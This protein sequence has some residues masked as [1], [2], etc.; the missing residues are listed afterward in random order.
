MAGTNQWTLLFFFASDNALSPLTVSDLRALKDAGFQL[1]TTVLAHFDPNELGAP[2]QI[3][4]VNQ[5]L[6]QAAQRSRIGDGRDSQARSLK[7]DCVEPDAMKTTAGG[8]SRHTKTKQKKADQID[9]ET[10]LRDFLGFAQKNHP[11]QHYM[12]FLVGHGMIVGS[13]TFLPDDRPMGAISLKK[14]DDILREFADQVRNDGSQFEL[15]GLHSCSMSAIEVAYQL[16]G[17]AN[18]MMGTEG[19]SYVGS[20]SYRQLLKKIFNTIEAAQKKQAK[21][22]QD[23]EGKVNVPNLVSELYYLCLLNATDYTFAGYS[24]DLSLCRLQVTEVEKLKEPIQQLV[25]VLKGA[26]DDKRGIELI[27]L[28]HWRAQSYWHETYTDL[29]D[30]CKCLR[31]ACDAK[32]ELQKSIA[33]ACGKVMEGIGA[34]VVHAENFGSKYQYS[35]GLSIYF[36]WSRPIEDADNGV[37]QRYAAYAFTR[38][39]GKK[40][41]WLNF[42][43]TYFDKTRR[44]SRWH[45]DGGHKTPS[46]DSAAF[47]AA[48]ESFN[49]GGG[50]AGGN[51]MYSPT[52]DGPPGGKPIPTLGGAC[53]CASIKNYPEENKVVRGKETQ[54]VSAFAITKGALDAFK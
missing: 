44:E 15:L 45:E 54:N 31:D 7:K 36:P 43:E 35:H 48:K 5:S 20:W 9:I 1:N 25:G 38:E 23:N 50:L 30:F 52:G 22:A 14:L 39:S 10:A 27:L 2:T 11:A 29:F 17:T 49:P 42:L 3:F 16:K 34:V 51:S 19:L 47:D 18:Y 8:A 21:E 13:D 24:S 41:S 32:I 37:L 53:A 40:N 4:N 33:D 12:L 26:L 6:K 46:G 28:A